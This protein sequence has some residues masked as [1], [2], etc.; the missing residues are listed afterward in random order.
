MPIQPVTAAVRNGR[1]ELQT[2]FALKDLCRQIGGARWDAQIKRWTYPASPLA[3]E[4]IER[5]M[6]GQRFEADQEFQKLAERRPVPQ[7]KQ[8]VDLPDLPG[9]AGALPAWLHQR[10]AFA[11]ARTLDAPMLGM[12]MRSG[13]SRVSVALINDWQCRTVLILCPVKACRIWPAQFEQYSEARYTVGQFVDGHTGKRAKQIAQFR[14]AAL[15]RGE[16]VAVVL[17]HEAC[18]RAE[19]GKYLRSVEWDCVVV[20]ESQRGKSHNGKFSRYLTLLSASAKKRICLTGTPMP[21]SPLD[22]FAQYRFLDQSVFGGSY[23]RFRMRYAVLGGYL[24]KEVLAFDNQDEMHERMNRI[25]FFLGKKE[26]DEAID[27]PGE[28]D[29]NQPVEMPPTMKEAYAK[30]EKD[31]YVRVERGEITAQNALVQ[32]LRLQQFTSGFVKLDETGAEEWLGSWKADALYDVLRDLQPPVVVWCRFKRDLQTIAE[33][34]EKLGWRHGEISGS[35]SDLTEDGRM[36]DWVDLM[37]VQIQSGGVAIDLTRACVAVSYSCGFSL[38]DYQQM[39][40]RL[41]GTHQKQKTTY[42]HLV[43]PGTVDEY[44]YDALQ[45]REDVVRSILERPHG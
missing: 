7:T 38:G 16:R 26:L 41:R 19:M 20:D 14:E 36:P 13:K 40:E 8:A 17:N 29:L 6:V 31:F 3:A 24:G 25:G 5:V 2:P 45:R 22:I 9:P 43:V 33:T 39:R 11:F 32:L 34:A 30:L 12:W 10:R 18:W 15:A 42:I 23:H 35:R 44:T 28:M 4:E 21:H 37:G 1:I 27:A